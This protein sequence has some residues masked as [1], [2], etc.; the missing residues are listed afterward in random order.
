MYKG[1]LAKML[2]DTVLDAMC[3]VDHCPEIKDVL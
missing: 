1:L 2:K 3:M